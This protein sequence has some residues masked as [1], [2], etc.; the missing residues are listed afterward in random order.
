METPTHI[1]AEI[2]RSTEHQQY[3]EQTIH[4]LQVNANIL[5]EIAIISNCMLGMLIIATA[6]ILW[7]NR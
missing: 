7:K 1:T 5:G 2:T 4:P 6:I 3:H